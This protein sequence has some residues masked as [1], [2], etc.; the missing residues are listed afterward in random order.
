MVFHLAMFV[1]SIVRVHPQTPLENVQYALDEWAQG[2]GKLLDRFVYGEESRE[3][4]Y[5]LVRL[6]NQLAFSRRG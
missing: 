5:I 2:V 6:S 4:K 3:K 1:A